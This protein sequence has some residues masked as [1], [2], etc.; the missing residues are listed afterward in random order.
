[1]TLMPANRIASAG[2]SG[3]LK[4]GRIQEEMDADITIFD[5]TTVIDRATFAEPA[6]KSS[7][8]HYVLVNGTFVVKNGEFQDGITPGC[9][10]RGDG[11]GKPSV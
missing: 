1:M 2:C 11:T 5:P 6:Q 10:V 3:M 4:K 7:G 9:P 8:I